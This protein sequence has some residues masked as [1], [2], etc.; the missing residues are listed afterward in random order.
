MCKAQSPCLGTL[1]GRVETIRVARSVIG[2]FIVGTISR[3]RKSGRER[4]TDHAST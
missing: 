2:M 1:I 4:C 3:I